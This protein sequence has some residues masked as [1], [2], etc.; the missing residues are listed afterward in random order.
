MKKIEPYRYDIPLERIDPQ[1]SVLEEIQEQHP[2]HWNPL[3][4]DHTD[5]E[6]AYVKN[7]EF[8]WQG[9]ATWCIKK[10]NQS[11][12]PEKF[13]WYD[14]END[15]IMH[16]N[17]D[18]SN[19]PIR[20]Q[21]LLALKNNSHNEHN[22]QYFKIANEEFEHWEEPL[23]NLFPE[24]GKDKLGI[25]LFIQP[26]GHTIWSH[27]DTFSSFIRRTGDSRPDYSNLRRYM[28]FVRDWDWG[29]FFH[30]GNANLG[31]WRSGDLYNIT[32]GVFHGSANAGFSPKITIH[33]SGEIK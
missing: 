16:A 29:H 17:D 31:Q 33:W 26:P 27:V 23:R 3:L 15:R 11:R 12:T 7:V 6:D 4:K 13:W 9:L 18:V 8:D 19:A 22:S 20:E 1:T 2:W 25:S 32:P 21:A 30:M 10:A 14:Y 24:F 28:I 5:A